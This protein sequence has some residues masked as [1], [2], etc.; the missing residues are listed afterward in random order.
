MKIFTFKLLILLFIF[1]T[2]GAQDTIIDYPYVGGDWTPDHN[3]IVSCDLVVRYDSILTIHPGVKVEVQN[4]FSITVEGKLIA[5]GNQNDSIEIKPYQDNSWT[6]ITFTTPS[7]PQNMRASQLSFI[8]IDC[9]NYP[10]SEAIMLGE[11]QINSLN[12][13]LIINAETA[14]T[15]SGE[16]VIND[17]T[18]CRFENVNQGVAYK[19]CDALSQ[20]LIEG[21]TFK[22]ISDKA[23]YITDNGSYQTG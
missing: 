4:G 14:V 2:A 11:H 1:Q 7:G 12:N 23:V 19:F 13:L 6:G 10:N 3:Y 5:N 9:G 21:C 22:N 8:K 17:V 16:A 18:N 20:I 15:I